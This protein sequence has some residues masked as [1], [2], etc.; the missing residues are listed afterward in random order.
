MMVR[1][2]Q[3]ESAIADLDDASQYEVNG[4]E[5]KGCQNN[6]YGAA[7][8]ES[9]NSGMHT[10]AGRIDRLSSEAK[11]QVRSGFADV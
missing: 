8:K 3:I 4:G 5:Y 10:A 2:V 6:V 1:Q 11:V 7:D 9:T